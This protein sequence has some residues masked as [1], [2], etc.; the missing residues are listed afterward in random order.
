[1]ALMPESQR[2]GV[3]SLPSLGRAG[4]EAKGKIESSSV[5]QKNLS[6]VDMIL[7]QVYFLPDNL[8]SSKLQ[9]SIHALNLSLHLWLMFP[10]LLSF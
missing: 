10:L 9:I 7:A 4:Q 3:W 8:I 5:L 6:I 2:M 1:M